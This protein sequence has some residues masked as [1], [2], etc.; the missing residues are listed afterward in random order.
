MENSLYARSHSLAES[1]L[2]FVNYSVSPY[3]AV[4][5]C[6]QQLLQKGYT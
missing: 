3:H 5:W 1:F 2:K 4:D 6:R